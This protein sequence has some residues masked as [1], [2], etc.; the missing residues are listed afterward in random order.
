M[1][2]AGLPGVITDPHWGYVAASYGLAAL[3]LLALT[4]MALQSARHWSKRAKDAKD[5]EA[6]LAE[7]RSRLD[8]EQEA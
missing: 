2:N 7:A 6:A 8:R 5:R 3:C 4:I 1:A